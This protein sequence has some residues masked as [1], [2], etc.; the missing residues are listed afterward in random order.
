MR[1]LST[2]ARIWSPIVV[3]RN[4]A[5]RNSTAAAV[6]ISVATWLPSRTYSPKW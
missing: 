3:Q 5:V 6:E 4:S 1:G 2:T